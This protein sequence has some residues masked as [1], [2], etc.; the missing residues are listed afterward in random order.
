M[1]LA[2]L[3]VPQI[4]IV[5]MHDRTWE[6]VGRAYFKRAVMAGDTLARIVE[7]TESGHFEMIV[8]TTSSWPVVRTSLRRL[9][10]E[11]EPARL[12]AR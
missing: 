7:A 5:G 1:Q 6:P 11:I 2:P 9:F 8:P 12:D 10:A 3:D 4:L